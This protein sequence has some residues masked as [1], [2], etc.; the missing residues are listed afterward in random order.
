MRPRFASRV[1]TFQTVIWVSLSVV[2]GFGLLIRF[3][4]MSAEDLAL[5]LLCGFGAFMVFGAAVVAELIEPTLIEIRLRLRQ[6]ELH[7]QL[8]TDHANI[9]H[10][11]ATMRQFR[12]ETQRTSEMTRRES[13]ITSDQAGGRSNVYVLRDPDEADEAL[14]G[15]ETRNVTP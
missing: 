9:V 6:L 1:F 8:T 3:R 15:I 12:R 14:A 5:S 13:E 10:L 2:F 7:Q 4:P 11:R